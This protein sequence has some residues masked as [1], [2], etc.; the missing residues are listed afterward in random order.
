MQN[1]FGKFKIKIEFNHN[2]TTKTWWLYTGD[3]AKPPATT[4]SLHHAP[5]ADTAED[6]TEFPST[7]RAL[8]WVGF[9]FK[10]TSAVAVEVERL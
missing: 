8:A 4:N 3:H 7:D 5:Y 6:A 2:G 9:L 10:H 1:A